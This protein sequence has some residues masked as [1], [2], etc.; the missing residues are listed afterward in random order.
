MA[1][2][3]NLISRSDKAKN[4]KNNTQNK[5]SHC[6][7]LASEPFVNTEMVRAKNQF[8]GAKALIGFITASKK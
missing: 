2:M 6:Q 8:S 7:T 4:R 1:K 3:Y 5:I